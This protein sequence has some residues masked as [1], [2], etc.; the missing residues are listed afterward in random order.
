MSTSRN[1]VI[2]VVLDH[3]EADVIRDLSVNVH[4]HLPTLHK[5]ILRA[6]TLEEGELAAFYRTNSQW[7]QGEE[8]PL[9]SM[10]DT[11]PDMA[12]Y[13]VEDLLSQPGDRLLYLYDFLN[14]WTFFCEVKESKEQE[15]DAAVKLIGMQG[16]RPEQAPPKIMVQQD[17]DE[18]IDQLENLL[19]LGAEKHN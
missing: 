3:N 8:I 2:R 13:K 4:I 7:D 1:I 11:V 18:D 15:S 6:F 14:L 5:A 9:M 12:H 10:D 17:P 19:H 16:E